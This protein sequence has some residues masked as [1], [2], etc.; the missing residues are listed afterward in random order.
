MKQLEIQAV[1]TAILHIQY[2]N[3]YLSEDGSTIPLHTDNIETTAK[4][5]QSDKLFRFCAI[6]SLEDSITR[7]LGMNTK[8]AKKQATDAIELLDSFLYFINKEDK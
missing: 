5:I 1:K 3:N 8:K 7:L 2:C 4:A 6:K